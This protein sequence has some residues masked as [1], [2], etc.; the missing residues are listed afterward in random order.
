MTKDNDLVFVRSISLGWYWKASGLGTTYSIDK[1]HAYQRAE[2]QPY[3]EMHLGLELVYVAP[4]MD[5]M[6]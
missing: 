3:A 6:G 5:E 4:R 1:A 2:V